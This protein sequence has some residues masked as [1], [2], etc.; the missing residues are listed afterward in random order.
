VQ[1]NALAGRGNVKLGFA[2]G[3]ESAVLV[4]FGRQLFVGLHHHCVLRRR[5]FA[6]EGANTQDTSQTGHTIYEGK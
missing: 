3:D 6:Y 4:D 2:L 5:L 1:A